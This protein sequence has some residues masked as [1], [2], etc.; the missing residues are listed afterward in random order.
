M[1]FIHSLASV[2][3]PNA[4]D[5]SVNFT[6]TATDTVW[7]HFEKEPFLYYI[8]NS[9]SPNND[10]I[11]DVFLPVTNAIDPEYYHLMVFN[12]WGDK[13][14][15]TTDPKEAWEGDYKDGSYYLP[16]GVYMYRLEIKSVHEE[17]YRDLEGTIMIFR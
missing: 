6:F 17:D 16:D 4:T 2:P 8:P 14:F 3:S 11:N 7:A 5:K 12:R 9:F 13:V 10:G 15:D 1:L